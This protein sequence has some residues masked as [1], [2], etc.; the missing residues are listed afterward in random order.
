MEM[1]S[2]QVGTLLTG[3]KIPDRK[4]R[5]KMMV[6]TISVIPNI[7]R[8]ASVSW[9]MKI[10]PKIKVNARTPPRMS[11]SQESY[12]GVSSYSRMF[13]FITGTI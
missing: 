2:S 6:C 3:K 7:A 4:I 12:L 10:I 9:E 13:I 8:A 5:G 1:A 11:F